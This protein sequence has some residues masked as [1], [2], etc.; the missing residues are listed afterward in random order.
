MQQRT[1]LIA[2]WKGYDRKLYL[3]AAI[4]ADRLGYDSFWLPEVW[5]Y[6]SFQLLTEI[7]IHT[8]RIKLGTGIINVF[9][10]SPALIAMSVATLDEISEGRVI[11][12]IGTSGKRVIEGFHAREFKAPLTQTRDVIRV[13]RALLDG[14]PLD[15]AGAKIG[16]YRKFTLDNKPVRRKVPIYVAALKEQAIRSIGELA[17]GWMPI[18]WPYTEL[19]RGREWIAQGAL[20]AGRNPSEI[21]TAPFTTAIP[22]TGRMASEKAR[23]IISFY[24]GGMGEYYKEMLTGMGYAEECERIDRLYK[25]PATRSQAKDAVTP[26]LVDALTVSGN[27]LHCIRELR[28]R[29]DFGQ[30][31]PI[32]NLPPNLPWPAL[33]AFITTMAPRRFP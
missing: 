14:T 4:L 5:G 19:G 24:I 6:E 28:R 2:F 15:Q 3:K 20:K 30:D 8:K 27:P 33:A 11:L 9:S 26:E 17:D 32:V 12:G 18:F 7:A 22:L 25:D 21:V 29:R 16:E 10:R 13:T 1:G 31:L 23:D